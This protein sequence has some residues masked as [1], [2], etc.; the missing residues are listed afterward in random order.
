MPR[1]ASYDGSFDKMPL[2][3]QRAASVDRSFYA[4][5]LCVNDVPGV[6]RRA[7]LAVPGTKYRLGGNLYEG[8]KLIELAL[9]TCLICPVQWE[10]AW[11]AIEAGECAGI[12]ADT[13]DNLRLVRRNK[14]KMD[15]ARRQGTP[16]QVAVRQ[17]VRGIS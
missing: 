12:W 2:S 10:C 14:A 4:K 5:A 11:A 15:I 1:S 17:L 9:T 16:V 13:L 8:E 6:P 7:W 3:V